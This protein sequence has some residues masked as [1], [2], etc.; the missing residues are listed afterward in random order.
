MRS[1]FRLKSFPASAFNSASVP[2][3]KRGL[4]DVIAKV[5]VGVVLEA[6][7]SDVEGRRDHALHATRNVRELGFHVG[8]QLFHADRSLK[9]GDGGDVDG[10]ACALEMKEESVSEGE[11]FALMGIFHNDLSGIGTEKVIERAGMQISNDT[12][13]RFRSAPIR[14]AGGGKRSRFGFPFETRL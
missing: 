11:I 5:E 4:V 14:S 13:N 9:N 12:G 6:W 7:Q 8:K 10:N 2:C 3:C 1:R